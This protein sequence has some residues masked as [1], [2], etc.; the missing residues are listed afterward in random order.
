MNIPF[1]DCRNLQEPVNG[2]LSSKTVS[3]GSYVTVYCNSGYMLSGERSLNC[4]DGSL[5]ESIGTC[6]AG[7]QICW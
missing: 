2:Y 3:H 6:Q 5:S 7:V 4:A 1:S